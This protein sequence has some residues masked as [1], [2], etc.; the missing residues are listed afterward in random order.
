MPQV[1]GVRFKKAGKI[2]YF[3]PAGLT[4]QEGD[5]VVVETARG[6]E[7]GLVAS[8]PRDV[9]EEELAEPLKPVLRK[10]EESDMQRVCQHRAQETESMALCRQHIDRHQLPMKLLCCEHNLEG[11]RLT[12]YFSA[13]KRVDFR[14]LVRELTQVFK[15]RVELRQVGPRDETKLLGGL[16]RCGRELCCAT[17]LYDFDPIS[18]RMAKEQD[19]PLNPM[20]ISG[21]CGRLLC[22]LAYEEKQY[23]EMKEKLP[24]PGQKVNTPVGEASVVWANP[25]KETVVVELE[26]KALVEYPMSQVTVTAPAGRSAPGPRKGDRGD[27]QGRGDRGRARKNGSGGGNSSSSGAP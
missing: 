10:A 15:K 26:S 17:Y 3:D 25:L 16:G 20:K 12:F 22:C 23:R 2:Y 9:P 8:A 13:E 5:R 27:R 1:I 6:V 21:L 11:N 19:L 7:V 18:I 14:D 24:P 4:F